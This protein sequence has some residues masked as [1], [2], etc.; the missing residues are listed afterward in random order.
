MVYLPFIEYNPNSAAVNRIMGYLKAFSEKGIRAHVVFF[1][2]GDKAFRVKELYPG[3][4]FSYMWERWY[5]DLPRINKLFSL[6]LYI[7][8]FIKRLSPGDTVYVYGFPDMVLALLRRKD[9]RVFHETT[10][11]PNASFCA[12]FPRTTLKKYLIA[13]AQYD[14]I[15]VISDALKKFF[16]ENG[17]HPDKVHIVNMIVDTTRFE[18]L[19]KIPMENHIAYCGTASNT[20]DGVDQL[21]KAF[22]LV[23]RKHSNYKLYII[24]STPSKKQ[25]FDNFELVK[26]LGIENSVVFTGE[27]PAADIPQM[28]KNASILALDRPDN[29]QA[30]YG[31][32]TKLGEY[33]LSTNPVIVTRVGDIPLFL[34]DG[35]SALLAEPNS[36]LSFSDRICWAIEHPEEAK[37]IGEC[38]RLVAENHFDFRKETDKLV[39]I[40]DLW[41]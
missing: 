13:C 38:G 23:L 21:I 18:G 16:I 29:L 19:H 10:E 37:A 28:L 34:T 5:V 41:N 12:Y 4:E 27:V 31:F 14:G 40:M 26:E 15:I 3:I 2:R 33:L 11:H 1:L 9:I 36:P 17:L 30:K 39:K 20:K 8:Q 35:E 32:P 22:A 6:R 25:T 24:G 7:H